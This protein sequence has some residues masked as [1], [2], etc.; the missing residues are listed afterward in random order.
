MG[1]SHDG[2]LVPKN[3]TPM[4]VR[5]HHLA[6]SSSDESEDSIETLTSEIYDME[7]PTDDNA[8]SLYHVYSACVHRIKAE[9]TNT[10]IQPCIVCG[11]NHRFEACTVLNNTEFL[12]QHY[13][14]YCQQ[15]RRDSCHLAR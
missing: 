4:A 6:L 3:N 2:Q 1:K 10:Y 12:K 15:I 14:R 11:G 9:P 8:R 5:V 7:I 13:I